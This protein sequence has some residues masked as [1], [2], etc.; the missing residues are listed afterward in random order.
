MGA[1]GQAIDA[2]QLLQSGLWVFAAVTVILIGV[3]AI[4]HLRRAYLAPEDEPEDV[5]ASL[6]AAYAAGE[7]DEA[8]FRRVRDSLAR[9][10]HEGPVPP[11]S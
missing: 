10:S 8:E 5:L 4:Q 1:R 3:A 7:L 11:A 2:T 9:E 6:E